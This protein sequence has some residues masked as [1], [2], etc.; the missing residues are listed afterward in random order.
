MKHAGSLCSEA[1]FRQT[2]KEIIYENKY[3]SYLPFLQENP[4]LSHKTD[5]V[6]KTT[7]KKLRTV[8]GSNSKML[9][10]DSVAERV[11]IDLCKIINIE[12]YNG[13]S[14]MEVLFPLIRA[15]HIDP[16]EIFYPE[17]N[18]VY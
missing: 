11:A 13:N 9:T 7:C 2:I 18:N 8:T 5:L 10:Q 4:Q 1:V 17:L 12:N 3:R 14:K 15:L 16:W 6:K